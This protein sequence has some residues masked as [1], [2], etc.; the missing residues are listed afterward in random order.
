MFNKKIVVSLLT[1]GILAAVASAGTWAYFND[2]MNVNNNTITA[3]TIILHG[4]DN[5]TDAFSIKNAIP[6]DNKDISNITLTNEGTIAGNLNVTINAQP[7]ADAGAQNLK[8]HLHLKLNGNEIA[9][10]TPI[11]LGTLEAYKANSIPVRLSYSYDN[12]DRAQDDEMGKTVK[13][14]I[15]YQLIQKENMS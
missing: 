5:N 9:L 14:D 7:T 12:L 13:Y 1:L 6:G 8:S 15:T 3:G 11:N 4:F 2:T 10:G